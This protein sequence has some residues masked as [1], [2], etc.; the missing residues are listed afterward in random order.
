MRLDLFLK[1]S[2]LIKRRTQAKEACDEGKVLIG[3][4]RVK[5]GR[6]VKVGDQIEL[7]F[8]GRRLLIQIERLPEGSIPKVGTTELYSVLQE[9]RRASIEDF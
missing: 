8:P 2:R 9:E 1:E 4:A 5:A 7:H 3:G 6:E